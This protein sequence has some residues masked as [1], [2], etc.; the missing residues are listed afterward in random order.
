M[1]I[2]PSI[3]RMRDGGGGGRRDAEAFARRE[4]GA[5]CLES[6]RRR[7]PCS[8]QMFIPLSAFH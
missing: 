2:V 5:N 3:K 4:K 8:A 1:E 7:L 6:P